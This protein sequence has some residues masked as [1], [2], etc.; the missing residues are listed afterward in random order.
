MAR[1]DGIADIDFEFAL[2][3]HLCRSYLFLPY[4]SLV[5]RNISLEQLFHL[6]VVSL[7]LFSSVLLDD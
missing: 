4:E 5:G 1:A 6:G 2:H 7:R 3:I